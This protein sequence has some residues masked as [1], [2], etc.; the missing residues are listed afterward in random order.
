MTVWVRP[1]QTID[2]VLAS[3]SPLLVLPLAGLG[4]ISR[5]VE[6]SLMLGW[7]YQVVVWRILLIE[8]VVGAILGIVST[9][10]NSFVLS[11]LGQSLGG[12]AS[13]FELRVATAW[14]WLPGIF[15]FFAVVMLLVVVRAFDHSHLF[16]PGGL[17]T[18]M[19]VVLTISNLWSLAVFLA[20]IS[21]VH[22]FSLPWAILTYV[23]GLASI[24][25]AAYLTRVA[26]GD[27]LGIPPELFNIGAYVRLFLG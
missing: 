22:Q 5:I 10:L 21:Q 20:M 25:A 4:G 2:H 27:I 26:L 9:Y 11:R 8:I 7:T 6:K 18:L 15:G 24:I 16:V 12:R 14:S 3:R 13:A 1:R 19:Q 23:I 17:L